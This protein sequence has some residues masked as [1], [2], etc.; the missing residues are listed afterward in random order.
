MQLV[1]GRHVA[2]ARREP[3][4]TRGPRGLFRHPQFVHQGHVH[5][6]ALHQN[7]SRPRIDFAIFLA[8]FFQFL[9]GSFFVCSCAD[10]GAVFRVFF[11]FLN[12]FPPSPRSICGIFFHFHWVLLG[13]TGFYWVLLVLLGFTWV[14]TQFYRALLGFIG[15]YWVLLGFT[16]FNWFQPVFL[17][18][19]SFF[20]KC[21]A[22]F[23]GFYGHVTRRHV[24]TIYGSFLFV[25]IS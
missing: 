12:F 18:S 4:E 5:A 13:F 24:C 3:A 2:P 16:K 23:L 22:D 6:V 17:F 14:L 7:V 9:R 11:F 1:R 10:I 19:N 15:F 25:F 21:F 20:C 8:L